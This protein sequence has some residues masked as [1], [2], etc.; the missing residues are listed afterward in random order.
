MYSI[1]PVKKRNTANGDVT[2]SSP[3]SMLKGAVV[4]SLKCNGAG[5]SVCLLPCSDKHLSMHSKC[6]YQDCLYSCHC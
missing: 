3:E 4:S 2:S 6:E 1:L 5:I